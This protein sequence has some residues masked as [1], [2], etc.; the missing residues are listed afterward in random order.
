MEKNFYFGNRY[1]FI[2]LKIVQSLIAKMKRNA[3]FLKVLRFVIMVCGQNGY[4][5]QVEYKN[6]NQRGK[7]I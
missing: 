4:Q 5:H 3:S 2:F 1:N 7:T 6:N